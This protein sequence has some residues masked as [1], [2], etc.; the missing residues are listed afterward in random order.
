MRLPS[1]AA[2]R[3]VGKVLFGFLLPIAL[4]ACTSAGQLAVDP[5]IGDPTV[6]A[7]QFGSGSRV[8][9]I[10]AFDESNNLSDGAP[11]SVALSAQLAATTLN[12]NPLTVVVRSIS[13]DGANLSSVISD[14]EAANV[15]IVIGSNSE[16]DVVLIAKS[17]MLRKV[18]TIS[19]TSF[20][21][22]ALQLYGGGYVPNEEAVTLVNE[23]AKRGYASV[24][25]VT[26]EGAASQSFTKSVLSLAAA[27]GINARPVDGT[28]D[29]QFLAGMTGMAAAGVPVS[30]VIFAAGPARAAAMMSLLQPDERFKGMAV[31]GNSGWDLTPKLP[32]ALKGAWYTSVA[33]DGM[34][35]FAEKFRSANGQTAT[36]NAAMVYDLVVLAAALPATIPEE[37]Y[38]PEVM[39]NPQGFKGFTGQF[40]FGP[41]GM[42]SARSYG[43]ATAK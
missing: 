1:V 3:S 7:N 11:N 29:S 36:L 23:A 26:T 21:D 19:M 14:F 6:P 39:T 16:S 8:V 30:A 20:S 27:A 28:T 13:P 33:S 31:I 40:R 38:H 37:P 10:L 2:C 12:G 34:T 35:E 18:P 25:V 17:M 43:I 9:G 24:A 42:L 5:T 32:A 15:S 22:L 41:T 4:A